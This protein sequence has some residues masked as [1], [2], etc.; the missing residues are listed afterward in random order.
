M[1][2][3]T[4]GIPHCSRFSVA[5]VRTHKTHLCDCPSVSGPAATPCIKAISPSEGWTTGGATVILIGD[6]FFDGLQ[7]VFGTMLVW[8]EVKHA[9]T[10][11]DNSRST[12]V[13]IPFTVHC[14]VFLSPSSSPLT[15]SGSR[16]LLAT[17]LGLSRSRCHTNLSSS[18]KERRDAS[19]TQV[20]QSLF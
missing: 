11:S 9:S 5:T 7:V 8:S 13:Y 10:I 6:N 19:S 18:V 20:T 12:L 14:T 1:S 4:V 2:Y 3:F 17:F 16:L 15:L